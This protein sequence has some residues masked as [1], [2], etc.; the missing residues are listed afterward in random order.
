MS[1][2][3]PADPRPSIL[4]AEFS[5]LEPADQDLVLALV[6][7]LLA[8]TPDPLSEVPIHDPDVPFMD[9]DE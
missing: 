7:R 6:A 2:R 8:G 3:Q 9:F 5:R 4:A 1:D